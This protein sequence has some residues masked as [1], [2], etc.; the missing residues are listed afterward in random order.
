MKWI[1]RISFTSIYLIV[2]FYM[3]FE[4]NIPAVAILLLVVTFS[5]FVSENG[6]LAGVGDL[7][8]EN[9]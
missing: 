3:L 9:N 6:V 4:T 1:K 7:F 8:H 2:A 5:R